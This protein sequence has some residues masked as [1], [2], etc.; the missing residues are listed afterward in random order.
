MG[1]DSLPFS[2]KK[3]K[4]KKTQGLTSEHTGMITML[5]LGSI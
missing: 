2:K 5:K 1:S 3:R 4:K